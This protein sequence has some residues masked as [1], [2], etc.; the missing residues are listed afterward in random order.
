MSKTTFFS[1][2]CVVK[3]HFFLSYCLTPLFLCCRESDKIKHGLFMSVI[4]ERDGI[5][6]MT[7]VFQL[8][9]FRHYLRT[10]GSASGEDILYDAVVAGHLGALQLAE[11]TAATRFN[12]KTRRSVQSCG[13]IL[14]QRRL[15]NAA[16]T[17]KWYTA[18]CDTLW[19]L[20]RTLR[21][22]AVPRCIYAARTAGS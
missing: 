14:R 4:V 1:I 12:R 5:M 2:F 19:N 8:P 18:F 22:F 10:S 11:F 3:R 20:F 15:N 9:V 16:V 6:A 13:Y 21:K 7:A 17:P